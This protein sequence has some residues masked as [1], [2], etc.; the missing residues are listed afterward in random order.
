MTR[1]TV[2]IVGAGLAGLSTASYAALNGYRPLV[3]E[4]NAFPGGLAAP[5]TNERYAV[6]FT[7][8][9]L[10]KPEPKDPLHST[11]TELGIQPETFLVPDPALRFIDEAG[12]RSVDVG[13]DLNRLAVELSTL[14]K[15]DSGRA[16][17]L[18]GMA[19]SVK[20]ADLDPPAK[21]L[22]LMTFGDKA[23]RTWKMRR[24]LRLFTEPFSRPARDYAREMDSPFIAKLVCD[25][26]HPDAPLWMAVLTL[27]RI[28]VGRLGFPPDGSTNLVHTLADR[29]EQLGAELRYGSEVAG[30]RTAGGRV[31][32]V[33]LAR[34][35]FIEAS[36]VISTADATRTLCELLDARHTDEAT[37]RRTAS[38]PV[39]SG[40]F[41]A[42]FG[43]RR[44]CSG[45]PPL[46]NVV[47]RR[48]FFIGNHTVD[49][50]SVQL[51]EHA[52]SFAPA[53]HSVVQ[54]SFP[55][56]WGYWHTLASEDPA[57]YQEEKE[58]LA[59][60]CLSRLDFYFEGVRS[61]VELKHVSTPHT[62]HRYTSNH[63]GSAGGWLPTP[64]A[65]ST[66][67]PHTLPGLSGFFMAGRWVT[68][69][70]E[71]AGNIQS[72]KNVVQLLCRRERRVFR[73]TVSAQQLSTDDR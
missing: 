1:D 38:W 32:G 13:R 68:P 61:L 18:I 33:E 59:A 28:A 36:R 51:F 64:E 37:R 42:T 10:L 29:A 6:P 20:A 56:D 19:T 27:A 66:W 46:W 67:I 53:G 45:L 3:L 71:A 21:P 31:T 35:E 62:I 23:L 54:V 34:G 14:R 73:S 9:L 30:I 65:L 26:F 70:G 8:G 4:Q 72:G 7:P 69:G 24:A 55:S 50:I 15:S 57:R 40:P 5:W 52:P 58:R 25:L 11:Y 17:E 41:V 43:I 44:R 60:E 63:Q 2:I 47:L 49:L 12:D 48:P 22:E 16:L 39:W